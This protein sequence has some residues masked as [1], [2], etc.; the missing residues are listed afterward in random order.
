MDEEKVAPEELDAVAPEELAIG[1]LAE[2]FDQFTRQ[3]LERLDVL[4]EMKST[5][6]KMFNATLWKKSQ[7]AERKRQQR[8]RDLAARSTH[9]VPLPEKNVW[10]RRNNL[11][12]KY[13][14]WAHVGI[15][16]GV[17]GDATAYFT[18]LASDWC[19]NTFLKKPI[20]RVSNR[21]N[22]WENGLRHEC[23]WTDMFG[24]ETGINEKTFS[25]PIFWNFQCVAGLLLTRME[26]MPD[27]VNVAPH[28]REMM[29][30]AAS[31]F[32]G[33]TDTGLLEKNGNVPFEHVQPGVGKV[34]CYRAMATQ[35]MQAYRRGICKGLQDDPELVR[36]GRIRAADHQKQLEKAANHIKFMFDLRKGKQQKEESDQTDVLH[37]WGYAPE[38]KKRPEWA[39]ATKAVV[40]SV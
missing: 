36:M 10:S 28:F 2:R 9:L 20:T 39:E 17:V 19:H 37:K 31:S 24:R 6:D 40:K 1:Q 5:V 3:V 7:D 35:M 27:W 26:M 4:L 22:Y 18:W 33:W 12:G 21:P 32:A 16:Y 38:L 11:R 8:A 13:L 15:Q 14:L 25:E 30:L 34:K 23:T 29:Q